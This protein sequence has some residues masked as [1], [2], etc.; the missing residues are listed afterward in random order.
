MLQVDMLLLVPV[1]DSFRLESG[2]LDQLIYFGLFG[3]EVLMHSELK[4]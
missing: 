1:K 4:L 2:H 3:F